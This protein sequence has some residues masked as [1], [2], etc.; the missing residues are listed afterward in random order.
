MGADD[1]NSPGALKPQ[2]IIKNICTGVPSH[3]CM[4]LAPVI[5]RRRSFD[6]PHGH[7]VDSPSIDSHYQLG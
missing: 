7:D 2:V 3:D 4:V 6:S 1:H 5:K